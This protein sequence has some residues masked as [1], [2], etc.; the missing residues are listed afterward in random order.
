MLVHVTPSFAHPGPPAVGGPGDAPPAPA[1]DLPSSGRARPL[2]PEERRAALVAATLP[3]IARYG[4]KVTTRQIAEAAGV[5]EGTI[6]R[7]FPDKD[8]LVQA[9]VEAA[10]DPL[11]VIAEL[12]GVDPALPLRE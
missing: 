1:A 7:V 10:L 2:P 6:F 11:P 8:A 4:T 5:A 9:A 3:L 12:A